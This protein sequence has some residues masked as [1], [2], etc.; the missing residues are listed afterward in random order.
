[1]YLEH[2]RNRE[3]REEVIEIPET[4]TQIESH[5]Y[6]GDRFLTAV[7]IPEGVTSIGDFAFQGCT[8]LSKVILP[9]TLTE[10]GM[11]AFFDCEHLQSI[12]LPFGLK[13]IHAVAFA[14]CDNL[15]DMDIHVTTEIGIGAFNPSHRLNVKKLPKK[16]PKKRRL[17]TTEAQIK[18]AST[19]TVQNPD[20]GKTC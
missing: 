9:E 17:K 10:I 20:L 5:A 1:M 16:A 12:N 2:Q 19:Q 11:G 14:G 4:T 3:I 15:N 8:N 18:T 13:R 7:T 6:S